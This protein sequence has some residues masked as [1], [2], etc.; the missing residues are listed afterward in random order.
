MSG[1]GGTLI[2]ALLISS[3]SGT[4]PL[5]V[6]VAIIALALEGVGGILLWRAI[7]ERRELGARLDEVE[8]RLETATDDTAPPAAPQDQVP[9][10]PQL[11][12]DEIPPQV[13]APSARIILARF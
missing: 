8:R 2:L 5:V 1:G 3:G 13:L 9:P 12:P 4:L 10:P 6:V 11:Q 7:P